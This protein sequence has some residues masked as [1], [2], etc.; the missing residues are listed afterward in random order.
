MSFKSAISVEGNF[1]YQVVLLPCQVKVSVVGIEGDS[2][3]AI[4][5]VISLDIHLEIDFSLLEF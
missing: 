5:L 3:E 1:K 4:L 2:V